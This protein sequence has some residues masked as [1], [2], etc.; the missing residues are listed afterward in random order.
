[1]AEHAL[2]EEDYYTLE[3]C[4]DDKDVLDPGVTVLDHRQA[5]KPGQTEQEADPDRNPKL[6]DVALA[7]FPTRAHALLVAA[8]TRERRHCPD[9]DAEVEEQDDGHGNVEGVKVDRG[10]KEAAEQTEARKNWLSDEEQMLKD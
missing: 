4:H 5:D 10:I 9:E 2:E 8:V 7:V 6:A 3:C 1:M